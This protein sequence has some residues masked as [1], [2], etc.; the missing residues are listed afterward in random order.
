M[1]NVIC[2][3]NQFPVVLGIFHNECGRQ[4]TQIMKKLGTL[5]TYMGW[6]DCICCYPIRISKIYLRLE[7]LTCWS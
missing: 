7:H 6:F 4:C 1:Q 2:H 3:S 5:F